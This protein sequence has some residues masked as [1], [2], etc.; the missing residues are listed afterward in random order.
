[1]QTRPSE[2]GFSLPELLV[3]LGIIGL[4]ALVAG[5]AFKDFLLAFKVKTASTQIQGIYR[6]G[7]QV[8]V[9]RKGRVLVDIKGSTESYNAVVDVKRDGG[10]NPSET[11]NYNDNIDITEESIRPIAP[12]ATGVDVVHVSNNANGTTYADATFR[13]SPDG[14]IGRVLNPGTGDQ[15]LATN[16]T[17]WKILLRRQI[18]N[19]RRD[20]WEVVLQ[21]SGKV[22]L[23]YTRVAL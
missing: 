19:R 17:E 6:L 2:R 4:L 18:N 1:M 13:L 11:G 16:E 15:V 22:S 7:R 5:P 9:A 12:I 23:K 20:D 3:V 21:R 10:G 14:T 8:A